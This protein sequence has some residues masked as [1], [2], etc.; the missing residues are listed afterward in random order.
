[1]EIARQYLIDMPYKFVYLYR[2]WLRLTS[3]WILQMKT[4]FKLSSQWKF[5][6]KLQ[7]DWSIQMEFLLLY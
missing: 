1:M 7:I 2:K 3:I 6:W 4:A 5:S